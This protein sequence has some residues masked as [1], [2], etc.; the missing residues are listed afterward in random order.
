[1]PA[2][3][4]GFER[5]FAGKSE[6]WEGGS[7]PT[8]IL[9]PEKRAIGFLINLSNEQYDKMSKYETQTEEKLVSVLVKDSSGYIDALTFV[10]PE[11]KERVEFVQ[12]CMSL[13]NALAATESVYYKDDKSEVGFQTFI[14]IT[15]FNE[16]LEES[17]SLRIDLNK[18]HNKPPLPKNKIY[19]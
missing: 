19:Q 9:S 14:D 5:V 6:I 2:H 10:Q 16:T 7:F 12:P 13:L 15:I 4:V 1:M 18:P 8:L 3:V 17:G 11:T